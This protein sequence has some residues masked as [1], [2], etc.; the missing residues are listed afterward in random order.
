MK[1]WRAVVVRLQSVREPSVQGRVELHVNPIKIRSSAAVSRP[2]RFFGR[3]MVFAVAL[4]A[5]LG[6]G[7]AAAGAEDDGYALRVQVKD[8]VRT[9]DGKTDNQPVPGVAVSVTDSTGL[10]VG[11]GITDEEGVLIVPV[12]SRSDYTITLDEST[13]PAGTKLDARTPAVQNVLTDSFVTKTKVITSRWLDP[14]HGGLN[15]GFPQN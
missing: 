1:F 2:A 12:P 6:F 3:L 8:Q 15:L 7:L 4:L 13:L 11:S 14:S 10:E 9:P 5:V